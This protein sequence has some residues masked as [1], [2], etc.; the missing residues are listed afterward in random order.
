MY[1]Q[2]AAGG[3]PYRDFTLEYPPVA[4]ALFWLAG[5][6]PGAYTTAFSGLM[7]ACLAATAVAGVAIARAL[8]LSRPRQIAAGVAVAASPL[9]LGG[10]MATRYDLAL[11]AAMAWMLWA[12]ITR[13]FT[14]MWTLLAVATLIKIVPL[15]LIPV[16]II[17]QRRET[18]LRRSLAGCGLALAGVAAVLAPFVLMSPSGVWDMAAYHLDRPLQIESTGSAYMLGLHALA[19]IPLTV[20]SSFG[21]QGLAG[22][23][24]A[25]IAGLCTAALM[26]LVAVIAWS[27]WRGLHRARTPGDV[28]LFMA[29]ACS[30]IVTLLVAGK[31]LSPQFMIWLLPAGLLIGGRYGRAAFALTLACLLAT[32]A[33]F[34]RL[35]WDLVDLHSGPI[36]LLALRDSLLIAL[37]AA[38]WPRPSIAGRPR[39]WV[40]RQGAAE[41]ESERAVAARYLAD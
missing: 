18:D 21:S 28:R 39:G 6:I 24:P 1:D 7:L 20:R 14:L 30:T 9:L 16:L 41:P 29:A 11:A 12:A 26:A 25:I 32:M 8:S 40:L 17:W 15:A 13:R 27:L 34:P 22:E 2:I 19:D 10:L 33:Y 36:A 23:G 3:I 4:G 5:I 35:Y 38:A 31:V 37:L